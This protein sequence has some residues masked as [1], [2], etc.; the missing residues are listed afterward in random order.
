MCFSNI[1]EKSAEVSSVTCQ[2]EREMM[3]TI[4]GFI[5][6][7]LSMFLSIVQ[8]SIRAIDFSFI[9]QKIII[10]SIST[11]QNDHAIKFFIVTF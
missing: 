7:Y 8:I 9:F 1:F 10:K 3:S 2:K 6:T 11:A 4:I 5:S